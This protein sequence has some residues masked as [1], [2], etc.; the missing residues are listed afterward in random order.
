MSEL[1]VPQHG[2]RERTS[3]DAIRET[4]ESRKKACGITAKG[5]TRDEIPE[6]QAGSAVGLKAEIP[7]EA[8]QNHRKAE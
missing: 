4:G 1:E 2:L 3:T 8:I 5:P 7:A 6:V